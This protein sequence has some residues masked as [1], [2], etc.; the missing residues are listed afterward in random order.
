MFSELT[1]EERYKIRKER[2]RIAG[3]ERAKAI[4][5]GRWVPKKREPKPK[6]EK[7]V[8][9][10]PSEK[11]IKVL[12]LLD[13]GERNWMK[14]GQEVGLT[15]E[16]VSQIAAKIGIKCEKYR[17]PILSKKCPVCQKDFTTKREEQKYCEINCFFDSKFLS[18]GE[19]Y[20]KLCRSTENLVK[21]GRIN[22]YQSYLCR[23]CVKKKTKK[24]GLYRKTDNPEWLARYNKYHR[25]YYQKKKNDPEWVAK[26]KAYLREYWKKKKARTGDK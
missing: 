23:P 11:A 12:E 25:E 24:Y 22:F 16:R 14:I 19:K 1:P 13:A 21:A 18:E 6:P 9:Q 7:T 15:R 2:I 5:E 26:R 4:R 10:Y 17:R 20:C 3:L 8:V